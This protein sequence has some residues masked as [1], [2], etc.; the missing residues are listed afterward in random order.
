MAVRASQKRNRITGCIGV[1][2]AGKTELAKQFFRK[3]A[4]ALV[5]DPL[6]E[7][8]GGFI[9]SGHREALD[10]LCETDRFRVIY[11]PLEQD[12]FVFACETVQA[13]GNCLFVVE[14]L[15]RYC[16]VNSIPYAFDD[17]VARG[18]HSRINLC[19]TVQRFQMIHRNV[20]SLTDEYFIF[21]QFEPVDL[22]AVEQ[23]F[24]PH[25]E[26]VVRELDDLEAVHI[27]VKGFRAHDPSTVGVVS[28]LPGPRGE[29]ISHGR[30]QASL[31]GEK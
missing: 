18:R 24:G 11:R 22:Q 25:V 21:R 2:G 31:K 10:Y 27:K 19:Y 3:A 29:L 26:R 14:E 20:T 1:K 17:I 30:L 9:V 8:E 5:V 15:G 16:D 6:A 7:Y 23:R 4:R 12:D 13:V 28:V